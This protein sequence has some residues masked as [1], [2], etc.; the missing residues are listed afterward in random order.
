MKYCPQCHKQY[1]ENWITFC[2]DD[3]TILIDTGYSPSQQSSGSQRPPYTPPLSEQPTWRSPDPNAPGG[4]VS[5][6]QPTPSPVWQPPPPPFSVQQSSQGLAIAS[7]VLG[8]VSFA[9]GVCLGP[10]PGLIAM[11]LGLVSLSQIKRDPARYG[12]KPLA[13][14]GVITGAVSLVLFGVLMFVWILG[15]IFTS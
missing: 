15:A 11:I 5:P 6:E 14:I 13:M 3:G 10:I 7:M 9:G 4:W 1:T 8:L 12:G 2:S